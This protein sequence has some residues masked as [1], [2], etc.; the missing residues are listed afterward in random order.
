MS[1]MKEEVESQ[2]SMDTIKERTPLSKSGPFVYEN[3]QDDADINDNQPPT[4]VV[5]ERAVDDA[6][7]Y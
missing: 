2:Y 6:R 7:E 3:V 4:S 5:N 1:D